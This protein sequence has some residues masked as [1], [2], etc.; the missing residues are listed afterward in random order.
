[1]KKLILLIVTV[2]GAL[3]Y[4]Y[5]LKDPN[6]VEVVTQTMGEVKTEGYISPIS[7]DYL[8]TQ[9]YESRK[10]EI[11]EEL[12]PG[13]NYQRYIASYESE[14]H[15][16]YGLLTVPD[17]DVP[18]G[19]FP[20][21]VFNHG[22]IPPK[23]YV[24]TEGYVAYVDYLARNGFVVFKIDYRGNGNSEGDASGTYFSSAYTFDALSAL[25]SLQK[26]DYVNPERIGM[27]G[28][29][30]AGNLILRS[31][32]VSDDVKAGVIWSGAVYSYED[33]TKYRISDSSYVHRPYEE[34]KGSAQMN[35]EISPEI[36]MIRERSEEIDFSDEFWSSISLTQNINYLENPIQIHHVTDD[37][38]VNVNYARDLV[39]VLEESE[40]EYEFYEYAGGGHNIS[41]PYFETAMERT[42]EFFKETL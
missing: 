14:G 6:M 21:I 15:E 20:A 33:F 41:S 25:S 35:R 10:L 16:V 39:E 4:F 30:M 38:V 13:V 32:L 11:E 29:S 42:L 27:W 28:H 3:G 7:I 12:N 18:D 19:G 17:E 9:S 5:F 34:R 24:T 23:Q 40:R 22:Y 36:Q 8:R 26:L 31:M 2:L 37:P 1:V